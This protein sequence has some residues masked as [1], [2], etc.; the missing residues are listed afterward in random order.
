VALTTKFVEIVIGLVDDPVEVVDPR[1]DH[2]VARRRVRDTTALGIGAVENVQGD[3][4]AAFAFRV[5]WAAIRETMPARPLDGNC[6]R[7]TFEEPAGTLSPA[8][9]KSETGPPPVG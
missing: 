5:R 1:D 8:G 9:E 2:G 7:S 4:A 6:G 3:E